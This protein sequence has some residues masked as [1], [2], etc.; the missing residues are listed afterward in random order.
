MFWGLLRKV[1]FRNDNT[2]QNPKMCEMFHA[3]T[4]LKIFYTWKRLKPSP[5]FCR[6]D[7]FLLTQDFYSKTQYFTPG[8]SLKLRNEQTNTTIHVISYYVVNMF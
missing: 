7:M 1:W 8:G 5:I 2:G 6:L 4:G 3:K